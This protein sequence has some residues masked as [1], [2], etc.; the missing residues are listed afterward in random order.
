MKVGAYL[1]IG[2]VL[3]IGSTSWVLSKQGQAGQVLAEEVVEATPVPTLSPTPS[4]SPSPSPTPSPTPKP[5][6]TPSPSP[7]P[8]PLTVTFYTSQQVNELVDKYAGEY[9][10]S[11]HV[12]RHVALCESGFD[13]L[14]NRNE[15]YA[16]LYQFG[17]V[18]WGKYR[19][20]MK[21]NEDAALRF[22]AQ[23]AVK[24]AAYVFSLDSQGIWPN[25]LPEKAR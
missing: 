25:C 6:V 21:E 23:A 3:G 9:G 4:S 22:D 15:P 10:V 19:D 18:T 11:P 16:G 20:K 24:T 13:P 17:P 7:S 14:A 8:S 12:L 1:L 2:L 5:T